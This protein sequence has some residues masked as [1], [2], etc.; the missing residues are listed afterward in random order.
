MRLRVRSVRVKMVLLV[1][2]VV[3]AALIALTVL[4]IVQSTSQVKTN[5]YASARQSAVAGANGFDATASHYMA[6]GDEIAKLMQGY[7]GS[8]RKLIDTMLHANLVAHPEI[9]A[10]YVGYEPNAFDGRDAEYRGQ[11]CCDSAGRF[12]PYWNRLTGKLQLTPLT[13][14]N[15]SAYYLQPKQ[16]LA[17]SFIEPYLYSG[18]LMTSY[19]AP[20][21]RDGRFV[22]IGGVDRSLASINAEIGAR[23]YFKTGYAFLVS[24][25]GIFVA[26][27]DVKQVGNVTLQQFAAG[28]HNPV[29]AGIAAA[30]HAGR[31][32]QVETTDPWSG[33]DVIM[34]YAPVT[35]GGW[36]YV[37]VVP[38]A[39]MLAGVN[40]LQRTLII[41]GVLALLLVGVGIVLVA[42]RF[43]RPIGEVSRAAERISEG[44]L[45]VEITVGG[46][47]EVGRM[48]RSFQSMV[49][50]LRER[51]QVAEAMTAGVEP[52]SE[53]DVLSHSFA[54]M[55]ERLAA[56]MQRILVQS[57]SVSAASR[58]MA[59]TSEE[60]GRA[61]AEIAAAVSSVA[62]GAE[63]QMRSIE[64][65]QRLGEQVAAAV[66][67]SAETAQASADAAREARQFAESGVNAVEEA[68][69]AMTAV[70]E[71]SSELT[72]AI[73]ALGEK[74]QRIGGIVDTITGIAGQTNL[75]ALNAAIEAARA[76]DQGRGFA[77]V[78]EEVRKLAEESQQAA[79]TIGA[80]IREI[81]SDTTGAV[82]IVEA[83]AQ[84]TREGARTVDGARDAFRRID[85]SVADVTTRVEEIAGV[86]EQIATSARKMQ[87]SISS[88][89]SVAEH[90]SASAEEVSA[91]TEQTS[92]GSQEIATSAHRLATTAGELERLVSQF[93]L[94]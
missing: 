15:D 54:A 12:L 16:T 35:D 14:E 8:D 23:H 38:K 51:A 21:I 41:V 56:I 57:S 22:G 76:G 37:V 72:S 68:N 84:R 52:R 13:G 58:G 6:L 30:I 27:R 61:V 11:L 63:E 83:G 87:D 33:K 94:T 66:R 77:V 1:L 93:K 67:V 5:A 43:T 24:N 55:R 34:S 50:Y 65:A 39:E 62:E 10:D 90:S 29:L 9:L 32:G 71:S 26:S 4:A 78:A 88:V 70:E 75:L 81:Q 42:T 91:S 80:L 48:G 28:R 25:G 59:S 69:A 85:G 18:V 73:R 17:D 3:A 82:E 46:A 31:G 36:G 89:A 19:T 60:A 49:E 45:D 47:D 20:I 2:P 74:G 92:A 53:R 79:A 64:Q 44:D 86:V 7:G 40:S